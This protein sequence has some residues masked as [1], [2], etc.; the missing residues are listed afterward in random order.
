MTTAVCQCACSN[1]DMRDA[2]NAYLVHQ[3]WHQD[4]LSNLSEQPA[5][6]EKTQEEVALGQQQSTSGT[7]EGSS[8]I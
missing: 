3:K 8:W 2:E 1:D 4:C 7:S 6:G 5:I